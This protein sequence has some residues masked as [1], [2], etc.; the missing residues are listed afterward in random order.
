MATIEK[1]GD[2][3][4]ELREL[5]GQLLLSSNPPEL[6]IIDD[7]N[8]IEKQIVFAGQLNLHY[9]E[10]LLITLKYDHQMDLDQNLDSNVFQ[11]AHILR[12]GIGLL[13]PQFERDFPI[14]TY[15]ESPL[16]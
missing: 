12:S 3:L 11:C 1:F 2:H 8:V 10:G 16:K 5:D 9:L 15:F 14:E 4:K 7:R 6:L 13:Q